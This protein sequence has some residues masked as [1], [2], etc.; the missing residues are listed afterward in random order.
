M[1]ELSLQTGVPSSELSDS[2]LSAFNKSWTKRS[3]I[4]KKKKTGHAAD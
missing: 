1:F 3:F 4:L 2:L